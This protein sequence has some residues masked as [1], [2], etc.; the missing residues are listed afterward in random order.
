MIREPG[1]HYPRAAHAGSI[2]L[3]SIE[4]HSYVLD[5]GRRVF[6][7]QGMLHALGITFGGSGQKG[8]YRLGNFIAQKAFVKRTPTMPP[9]ISAELRRSIYERFLFITPKRKLAYGYEATLLPDL[10]AAILRARING[11]LTDKVHDHIVA[12]AEVL[13]QGFARVGIIALVDEAT[14]Y[15]S[16]R[17]VDALQAYLRRFLSDRRLPW[18]KM[19]P[20]DYYRE[21]FRL[22]GWPYRKGPKGPRYAGVLTLRLIYVPLLMTRPEVMPVLQTHPQ[23]EASQQLLDGLRRRNTRNPSGR[24][25]DRY[26]QWLT[27]DMGQRALQDQISQV[28]GFMAVSEI[29]EHFFGLFERRFPLPLFSPERGSH[30]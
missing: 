2:R 9:L 28:T 8:G 13:L 5:D 4:L 15:Q 21:M 10:V 16:S 25:R 12:R 7:Q 22:W 3:G 27:T 24:W 20:D 17:E 14:G 26:H 30:N 29:K 1:L 11:F 18:E 19:F 23:L 6:T